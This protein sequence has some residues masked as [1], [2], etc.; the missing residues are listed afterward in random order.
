M[1]AWELPTSLDI[2]GVGYEI[3]SDF[4]DVLFILDTLAD[5]EYEDDEKATI[6][7]VV[8][9][10]DYE[11]IPRELWSE[12]LKKAFDFINGGENTG[13]KK[14]QEQLMSWSQDA[15]LIIPAVNRVVG[16]E[17]RAE[18]YMHWW[19]FLAAYM[20][21]GECQF[22]SILSI[23]SKKA[24]HKKLEKYEQEY[25]QDNRSLIDLKTARQAISE[26]EKADI[27]RIING[28]G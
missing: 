16:R 3:R 23:R 22:S 9:Y 4:R 14:R 24:K 26:D 10:K 20:E 1:S 21:I 28:N 27:L 7:L 11:S 5:P 15:P 12:A 8:M 19:T 17:I 25:Y 2:G 13:A 18:Q 6:I